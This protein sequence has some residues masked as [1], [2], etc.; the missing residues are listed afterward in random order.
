MDFSRRYLVATTNSQNPN[1]LVLPISG[2]GGRSFDSFLLVAKKI[3]V[4]NW[5]IKQ[6][7]SLNSLQRWK[8]IK[9]HKELSSKRKRVFCAPC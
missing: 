7:G 8:A 2:D 5:N 6:E 3:F 1:Y 9:K 4:G